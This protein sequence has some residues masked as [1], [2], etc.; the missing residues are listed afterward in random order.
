MAACQSPSGA[1]SNISALRLSGKFYVPRRINPTD[2]DDPL[3]FQRHHQIR[4]CARKENDPRSLL[5]H[6][7]MKILH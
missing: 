7:F 6:M 1:Q 5:L 3:T 4:M 2:F